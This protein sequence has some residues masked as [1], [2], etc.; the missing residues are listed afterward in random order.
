MKSNLKA[1]DMS[2]QAVVPLSGPWR[3]AT[4]P[5]NVGREQ[6]WFEKIPAR[7]QPAPVPGIIQQVYPEYYGAAWS[8]SAST[9]GCITRTVLPGVTRSLWVSRRPEFW[10]GITTARSSHTRCFRGQSN[11]RRSWRRRSWL[12]TT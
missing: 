3:I 10:I 6:R 8:A 5:S 1:P 9:T 2:A 12:V 7:A 4:D 11:R